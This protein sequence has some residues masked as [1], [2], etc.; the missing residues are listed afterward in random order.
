MEAGNKTL[1]IGSGRIV[2]GRPPG[3]V[4]LSAAIGCKGL[5]LL[6]FI[7]KIQ[8]PVT[9][10][11]QRTG[12]EGC[13]TAHLVFT[14]ESTFLVGACIAEITTHIQTPAQPGSATQTNVEAL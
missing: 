3:V 8:V 2:P 5:A 1:F 6:V 10:R 14:E 13:S 4:E 12:K 9:G 11:E 7:R